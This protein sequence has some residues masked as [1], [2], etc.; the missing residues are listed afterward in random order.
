ME[1]H[2]N[3]PRGQLQKDSFS[4]TIKQQTIKAINGSTNLLLILRN[5]SVSF[6]LLAA[7]SMFDSKTPK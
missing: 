7:T 6:L 5:E 4:T 1:P 2:H 3:Q